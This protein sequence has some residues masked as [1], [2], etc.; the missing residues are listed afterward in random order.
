MI[1][2]FRVQ[3]TLASSRGND[4]RGL[5]TS[6]VSPTDR[7][8]CPQAIEDSGYTDPADHVLVHMDSR[9][10]IAF[11]SDTSDTPTDG[12]RRRP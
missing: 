4:K 9:E 8:D 6:G 3:G 11:S 5:T 10:Q 1:F 12:D 2:D 7:G